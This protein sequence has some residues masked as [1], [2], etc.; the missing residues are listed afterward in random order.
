VTG[1]GL[2]TDE[3]TQLLRREGFQVTWWHLEQIIQIKLDRTVSLAQPDTTGREVCAFTHDTYVTAARHCLDAAAI[4]HARQALDDWADHYRVLGWS[5]ETP[6]FLLRP[7]VRYLRQLAIGTPAQA[8]RRSVVD[9]IC[10]TVTSPGRWVAIFRAE[11]SPVWPEAEIVESQ[12]TVQGCSDDGV[13]GEFDTALA[14]A[15]LGLARQGG[16]R[17]I[18]AHIPKPLVAVWTLAGDENAAVDFANAV[19]EPDARAGALGEIAVALAALGSETRFRVA[20][21]AAVAAAPAACEFADSI[22]RS[23]ARRLAQVGKYD[24]AERVAH[25]ISDPG[26]RAVCLGELGLIAARTDHAEQARSLARQISGLVVEPGF[27]EGYRPFGVA[28]EIFALTGAFDEADKLITQAMSSDWGERE[29]KYRDW[30]NVVVET[31]RWRCHAIR[32]VKTSLSASTDKA[33]VNHPELKSWFDEDSSRSW[34]RKQITHAVNIAATLSAV[35]RPAAAN[36]LAT[37]ALSPLPKCDERSQ[38][39]SQIRSTPDDLTKI[40]LDVGLVEP[41]IAAVNAP[42]DRRPG[43]WSQALD[44]IHSALAPMLAE[45][46]RVDEAERH[47]KHIESELIRIKT[48]ANM[49][50]FAILGADRPQNEAQVARRT[51]DDLLRTAVDMEFRERRAALRKKIEHRLAGDRATAIPV[52]AVSDVQ[53]AAHRALS[54]LRHTEAQ[55][56]AGLEPDD[57]SF[58]QEMLIRTRVLS[59]AARELAQLDPA[60]AET[61]VRTANGYVRRILVTTQGAMMNNVRAFEAGSATVDALHRI[62]DGN[63]AHSLATMMLRM[64][65]DETDSGL[66]AECLG[67]PAAAFGAIDGFSGPVVEQL[68]ALVRST[69]K[70]DNWM[71]PDGMAALTVQLAS[72]VGSVPAL[73]QLAADLVILYRGQSSTFL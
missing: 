21:E 15:R 60:L 6:G 17:G 16:N 32:A 26:E 68:A 8:D 45:R 49:A 9:R 2:T 13:L 46:G 51:I 62:G 24:D 7:Y 39:T 50:Y 69:Q 33:I 29:E 55:R 54:K 67:P 3:L 23:F 22:Q 42:P 64:L 31:A 19:Q 35:E 66:V 12:K 38:E 71:G 18:V 25:L 47:A 1:G 5:L 28:A 52:P 40:L 72:V 37:M 14:L 10:E 34:S 73:A 48:Q 20:L 43:S 30:A 44:G 11:G 63:G 65:S 4:A 61:W 70:L 27:R 57:H 53:K 59:Q 36:R 58:L 56:A 41:V